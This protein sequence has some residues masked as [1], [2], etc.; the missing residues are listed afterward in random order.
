[1]IALWIH[2]ISTVSILTLII[3]VQVLIYPQFRHVGQN[4]LS[5]Y[6]RFHIKRISWVVVPIMLSELLS[7]VGVWMNTELRSLWLVVG[8]GVLGLIWGLTFTKIAPLHEKIA[9][10]AN[11]KL[12]PTLVKL[13]LIRTL[14]WLIKSVAIVVVIYRFY[15]L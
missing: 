14:L 5:S 11:P 12:I 3:M 7:L 15:N 8:T 13:N 10:T 2:A 4:E 1:M 9:S 6:S